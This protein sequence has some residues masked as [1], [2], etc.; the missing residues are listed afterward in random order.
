KRELQHYTRRPKDGLPAI[1]LPNSDGTSTT[2]IA[3][4][5]VKWLGVYFD[6]RLTFTHHVK[7]LSAHAANTVNGLTMLANTVRGLSQVHLR[8][9]YKACVIPVMAY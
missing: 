7:T 4:P 2:I 1:S 6:H 8:H 3:S 9:L 5:S